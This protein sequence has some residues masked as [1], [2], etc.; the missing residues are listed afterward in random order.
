MKG[1][2]SPE[3]A[4]SGTLIEGR[5]VT[6]PSRL[7]SSKQ[8]KHSYNSSLLK[9]DQVPVRR[10]YPV[11]DSVLSPE[12]TENVTKRRSVRRWSQTTVFVSDV[13][14]LRDIDPPGDV[15]E[16]VETG[17]RP[18][19]RTFWGRGH[20]DLCPPRSGRRNSVDTLQELL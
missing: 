9:S 13:P 11:W 14:F 7:S 18:G 10:F 20:Q 12:T 8:D 6:P 4:S 1:H 5:P 17:Q 2:T 16:I 3:G 15:F 19:L